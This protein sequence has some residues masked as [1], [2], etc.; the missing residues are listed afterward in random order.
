M[1]KL[2]PIG[3][4]LLIFSGCATLTKSQLESISKYS[5]ATKEYADYPRILTK[6]YMNVQ[7]D[8][9]ILSNSYKVSSEIGSNNVY[10][11]Y[12]NRKE[13]LNKVEKIDLSFKILKKYA[14]NLEA[15]STKNYT[16]NIS[17]NAGTVGGFV[18]GSIVFVGKKY[19]GKNRGE[20]LKEYIEKG[21]I[22]IEK[23]SKTSKTFLEEDVSKKWISGLDEKLKNAHLGLRQQILAD[24]VNYPSN[25]YNV[26]LIDEKV[27]KIYDEIYYLETMNKFLIKSIGNL[28]KAHNAL[29]E[30]TRQKQKMDEVLKE[31]SS[32]INDVHELIEI[33]NEFK[34]E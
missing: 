12:I 34:S 24:T 9:F 26:L 20:L 10:S 3:I 16:K 19:I 7:N 31:V 18:Y 11:N 27:S 33:H 22:V 8:I 15:I 14:K 28:Y 32:F 30:N 25:V 21:N 6:K 17:E 2:I 23:L 1:K 29:Y 4:V 5:S 13:L